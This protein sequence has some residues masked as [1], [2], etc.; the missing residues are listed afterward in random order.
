M[1]SN[2]IIIKPLLP[3]FVTFCYSQA[4][5]DDFCSDAN[6]LEKSVPHESQVYGNRSLLH[7]D[8]LLSIDV[9]IDSIPKP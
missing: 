6:T 5:S 3:H 9:Q 4:F 2:R 1:F 8:W 7:A